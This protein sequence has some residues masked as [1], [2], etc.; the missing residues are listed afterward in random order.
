[1]AGL[2]F[3]MFGGLLWIVDGQGYKRW[4]KPFVILGMNA[5]AIYMASELVDTVL[6]VIPF[7]ETS[8][9]VW[10]YQ[11]LFAPL[12]SGNNAS[13]LYAITYVLSMYLIAWLLYRRNWFLRV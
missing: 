6:N 9:R 13:L 1:M 2:D 3:V 8:L 4:A 7:G 5:I 10:I 12:A 11:S